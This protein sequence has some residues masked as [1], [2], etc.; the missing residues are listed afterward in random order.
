MITVSRFRS[1]NKLLFDTALQIRETVFVIEQKVDPVLE[2]DEFEESSRHY[3]IYLD[4]KPVGTA[5]WRE[6]TEG[7]KL[8]RFAVLKGYRNKQI[9]AQLLKQVMKDVLL[10]GK[11]IYLHAQINAL[12]FY[13]REGFSTIGDTFEEAEIIHYKMIFNK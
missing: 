10:L 11:Q 2:Y 9:G 4:D 3:L 8:E 13:E 7:I 12:S 6:T 1:E 5:R